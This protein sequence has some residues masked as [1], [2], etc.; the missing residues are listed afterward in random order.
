MS[1]TTVAPCVPVTS[2][3]RDPVNEAA[4]PVTFPVTFPVNAPLNPTEV[5]IPVEGTNDNLVD[6]VFCGRLP[7]FA[8]THVG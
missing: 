8:V 1:P 5:N 7:V 2:P 4:E 6:V 3:D